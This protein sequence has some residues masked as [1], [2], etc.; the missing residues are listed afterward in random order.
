MLDI[1]EEP[2]RTKDGEPRILHTK[3]M[4]LF[5]ADGAPRYLLGISEDITDRHASQL[6]L[7]QAKEEAERANRAKSEFL[8]RMSHELRTPLNAILGFGQ[9]LEH[10]RPAADA[11]ARASSRSCR[12][13]A[14]SSPSS[15]RCSTSPRIET[16]DARACPPSRSP[17]TEL[18][19]ETASL[20]GRS[21]T[22][23]GI[24]IV[25]VEPR[26]RRGALRPRRPPAAQAGPAE[27]AVQ[28]RQVQPRRRVGAQSP[29]RS[30]GTDGPVRIDVADTGPGIPTADWRAS[31]SPSSGSGAESQRGR[32]HRASD[33][34]LSKRL[35]EAMGG[36]IGVQ[37][38]AGPGTTFWV[39]LPRAENPMSRLTRA[40]R[41]VTRRHGAVPARGGGDRALH[42]GQPV[43][44]PPGG[45]HSGRPRRDPPAQL[46][47]R[48]EGLALAR[49]HHPDLILLDLHLP[50]I[51]GDE[52]LGRLHAD[53]AT[54]TSPSSCSAPTPRR[55]RSTGCW[56]PERS[57]SDQ[58][59][60]R[61][62]AAHRGR[63]LDGDRMT[64]DPSPPREPAVLIVDDEHANVRLL[65]RILEGAGYTQVHGTTDARQVESLFTQLDPDIV[66]LDLH[67]PYL[68][69]L[70][71]LGRI[72]ALLP[73]DAFVPVLVLTA[74]TTS[75]AMRRALAGGATDFLI[76]PFDRTEVLLRIA[77]LLT[78]R[79]LHVD[80]HAR[81]RDLEDQLRAQAEREAFA[82]A[83]LRPCANGSGTSSTTG[84]SRWCSNPSPT[85]GRAM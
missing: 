19:E 36:T 14:T 71:V 37:S 65:E 72:H 23:R 66:L 43:Q 22:E 24:E 63:S 47:A 82:A 78:T 5:G 77:N 83:E 28:R 60:R 8:S 85:W 52:V 25:I 13:G 35:I 46:H 33:W 34:R 76:K 41:G 12:A 80:L 54:A 1:P 15:T 50:D 61:G 39:E 70:A 57:V 67:M 4:P 79:R 21:P 18:L 49:E 2:I 68:D 10:R 30:S 20:I 27:P 38:I 74:D 40:R 45:T 51:P 6:A 53:P 32:G 44:P 11:P 16:G 58:A 56:P 81:N 9:L 55:A 73:A 42:R 29:A 7:A 3:K 31:S 62:R 69:G 75:G 84:D 48:C 64:M 26:A 59:P 17:S